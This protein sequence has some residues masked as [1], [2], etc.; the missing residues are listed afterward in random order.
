MASGELLNFTRLVLSCTGRDKNRLGRNITGS[1]P[2]VTGGQCQ[3]VRFS[4]QAVLQRSPKSPCLHPN[5]QPGLHTGRD[6]SLSLPAPPEGPRGLDRALSRCFRMVTGRHHQVV[7]PDQP[8]TI[9]A[10]G[11]GQSVV[12]EVPSGQSFLSQWLSY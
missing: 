11:A 12:S 10:W 4:R 6:P 9:W 8:K 1:L 7:I 2:V 3:H 5:P